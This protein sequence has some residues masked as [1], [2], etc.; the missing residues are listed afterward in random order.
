[1]PNTEGDSEHSEE[2]TYAVSIQLHNVWTDGELLDRLLDL[3]SAVRAQKGSGDTLLS[4][5]ASGGKAVPTYDGN[6]VR[7]GTLG[8]E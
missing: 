5:L 6:A 7:F 4:Q 1:M 8:V 2:P 3:V